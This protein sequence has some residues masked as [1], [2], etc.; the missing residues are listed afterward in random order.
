MRNRIL[1]TRRSGFLGLPV[2]LITFLAGLS[3]LFS[4]NDYEKLVSRADLTYTTPVKRS[5]EGMPVGNGRMGSLVWTTP[6]ALHFQINR[7]D[8]FAQNAST[9]NFYE[10]HT[11][12]C[13]GLG[14][15]DIDF[16]AAD[17]VFAGPQFKQQLSCYNGQVGVSGIGITAKVIAWMQKDVMAIEVEDNRTDPA[18][19]SIHL[20]ALRWPLTRK[21][22]HTALSKVNVEKEHIALKQEFTEDKYFCGS[23]VVIGV[24]GRRGRTIWANES[25]VRIVV[26]PGNGKFVVFI[27][28][29]ATFNR[30]E[31]LKVEAMRNL[32]EAMD[33]GMSKLSGSNEKWW[34]DFW[35]K[36]YVHMHS[37]DG[38]AD[39]VEKNY[40]YY[41]YVMASSSRGEYP[42]KFNGML[43]TTGGDI[44]KWGSLFWG[45]NQSCLYN[46]LF[47][48]NHIELMSPMFSMYSS[49]YESCADAALRQW[50]SRGIYIPET[51]SFDG[52]GELPDQV[53]G[54]MQSL[55]LL[56]KPW[57]ERSLEFTDYAST[58]LPFLSRWNWKKDEGWSAG[59]WHTSDKGGGPFGH[60]TH[61]FSRGAKIAYQYWLKYEYTQ[62]ID[63]LR[64]SAYPMLKGVAE[65][66]RNFPHVRKERDGR[67]HIYHVNDNESVWGGHNT[68]EEIASMMGV[69]PAAI[70]AS[71]IL[72]VDSDLR[73]SWKEFLRNLSPL[74]INES[75]AKPVW[76]RS[77]PP[78]IQGDGNRLP[79]PNTLPV[80]FFD[81]CNLESE[82][83]MRAVANATFDAYF[84]EGI[85]EK[86]S[87]YVLSKLPVAGSLLGRKESTRHLLPNQVQS[88]EVD[89]M[90]NRMD[91]R[92]GEQTTSV[93]RLGRAA[94][95]LHFALCQSVPSAPGEIP[96]IHVFPAWPEEWDAQ[97]SLLCRG[98]F[99]V[100]SKQQKG[101]TEFVEVLS[102]EGKECHLHN[103][104]PGE[105]L[106]IYRNGKRWK[107]LNGVKIKLR[108]KT[109]ERLTIIP[110][111]AGIDQLDTGLLFD[112]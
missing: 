61:I 25:D 62:D 47:A 63:W 48:A 98:G 75:A 12:Y 58:K 56:K 37:K 17:D 44:R 46:A 64:N 94:E 43:W 6:S 96:V 95:A 36:S 18:P 76:K 11:D 41:L 69:F 28:S 55:Y 106:V 90:P 81:L 21:G 31:D 10:R 103:P 88:A 34:S 83:T 71:E 40:T 50:G 82:E 80:W 104:W 39:M 73:S 2:F 8:V 15:V 26:P 13:G 66:Y 70:R 32:H 19:V 85:S 35:S 30:D 87:I 110:E 49:M 101:T 109:G 60:V 14:F 97:F 1:F 52:L 4:Q 108:T 111:N 84:P 51:V 74:P 16:S 5:E 20:R 54:E 59:K 42:A 27:A 112:Q 99:L 7:V 78:M 57:E 3:P 86:Q 107:K 68:I 79:D 65:F 105:N 67:Y 93:Q 92:E 72:G 45:A 89:I 38:V 24:T 29:A 53:A 22:N 100:S 9:N 77:L 33:Q 23:L 102:Q 91:L